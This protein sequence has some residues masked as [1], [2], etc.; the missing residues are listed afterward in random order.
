[1]KMRIAFGAIPACLKCGHPGYAT[2]A[3]EGNPFRLRVN[4]NS[5]NRTCAFRKKEDIQAL[6]RMAVRQQR[7][8]ELEVMQQIEEILETYHQRAITQIQA[9]NIFN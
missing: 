3:L 8:D 1:M 7:K 5:L 9:M 2:L 4:H 6:L